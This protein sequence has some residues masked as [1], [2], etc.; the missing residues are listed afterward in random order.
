ML[1]LL[2]F[3]NI[4]AV[5]VSLVRTDKVDGQFFRISCSCCIENSEA[6]KGCSEGFSGI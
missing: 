3:E 1:M 6:E 4:G 2:L 5:S